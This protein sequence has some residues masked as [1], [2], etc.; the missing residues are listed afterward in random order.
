ME[1]HTTADRSNDK[2]LIKTPYKKIAVVVLDIY[3]DK[4]L[5]YGIKDEHI[6]FA[7]PGMRISAPIRG[8]LQ[9]GYILEIKDHSP[10]DNLQAINSFQSEQ[11]YLTQE[12]FELALWMSRY[13]A[14]PLSL[15]FK[16]ILPSVIASKTTFKQQLFVIR[17][18]TK[19]EIIEY[20]LL[21][22][23]KSPI[24]VAILEEM[25][26][27]K[28]GILLTELLEKAKSSRSSVDA[29]VKKGLLEVDIVRID[30]SPLI[31]EEYFKTKPKVLNSQQAEALQKINVSLEKKEFAVHLLYGIT[32][33]GK[34]EVYLQAIEKA[35][36]SNLRVIMLVPEIALTSQTIERFKSRF[37]DYI[38]ILHHRLSDG[39]RFDEWHKILNS[40]AKIVIGARSAIFSPIKDLGLII[41]DEEHESSYKQSESMPCYHARDIAV[42]R[43]KLSQCAVILGSATPS[44]ESYHHALSGKYIL[45]KLSA[46]AE[47]SQLPKVTIVDMAKERE[48]QGYTNYSQTLLDGIKTRLEKGEKTILFLNRRGYHTTLFCPTCQEGI[49]C[50]H[51]DTTLT[52][53]FH[54]Q[55]LSCHLCGYTIIPPKVCP[56][57]HNETMK[58]KGVGTEQIERSLHAIFPEVRTLRMDADTTRHKGSHQKILKDFG[59]GKADVLIGTQMIAKGLHFPD[60]TLVGVL[61][62]DTQLNIPDFKASETVFQII[63][64]VAGRAGR[65]ILSGEVII[66]TFLPEN[67]VLQL[68]AKQDFDSF[69]EEEIEIRRLFSYS[70]F[71]NLVKIAFVGDDEKKTLENAINFHDNL[72]K[73]LT[74]HYLLL[75]VLPAGHAKVKDQYRFQFFL[76]GKSIYEINHAIAKVKKEL[77]ITCKI[78]VDINPLSTYF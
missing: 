24:Q 55:K 73:Q 53:H 12:L 34:T 13:Y 78:L 47:K 40:D 27:V 7:A 26:K 70:P 57:C 48:K 22:R 10:F 67:N 21:N 59:T 4:T 32:G 54:D 11:I 5:D 30:R 2:S 25:L 63:T 76:K 31:N 51:C 58:Y 52:F 29:L 17:K 45:S 37:D 56:K 3:L 46:R 1:K 43:G 19:D 33:S 74:E 35:L 38:S 16:T 75:P 64:Q 42:M 77:K 41:V 39:E 71:T 61:N 28:K 50:K 66:Q 9:T 65:G 18:K 23:E 69:F 20:C 68:A 36:K 62:T 60:V 6:S 15:I 72:K 49:N 14:S 44:L 8:K